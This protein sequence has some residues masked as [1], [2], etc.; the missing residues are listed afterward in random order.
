MDHLE[1]DYPERLLAA[2]APPCLSL[3]QPTHPAH[4]DKQQ[5]P[6]RFRNLVR[7]LETQL[8]QRYGTSVAEA[9]LAP[10][11]ALAEDHGFWNRVQH[12]LAVLRSPDEFRV[13]RLQRSVPEL[14]L[15]AD[16]FHTKPLLRIQQSADRFQVLALR[17]DRVELYEGNRDTVASVDLAPQV[18]A[19]AADVLGENAAERERAS[20][21]YGSAAPAAIA[22]HGTGV[23]E[24][25]RNSETERYFRAVD[26][27]TTES[28]SRPTRLPLL[29]AALPEHHHLFRRVSQNPYLLDA[30]LDVHPDDLSLEQ[31]RQRAWEAV[32]PKYMARLAGLV[33]AFHAAQAKHE[34]SADVA[35]VARAAFEGRVATMLVDADRH[36][37]GRIEA[38]TGAITLVKSG[39][40]DVGDLLDDIGEQ[41]LRT[42]GEVVVVPSDR[43]PAPGGVAAIYRY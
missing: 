38:S 43:M 14:A 23:P 16:S 31:L 3:Y 39:A 2:R 24:D 9:L 33:A 40:A 27:A 1:E 36:I 35:D 29:L 21:V 4:P 41:V 34:G 11:R 37:P 22:R 25:V 12:G 20:R 17:R 6:I 15:V 10:L 5:D 13:Y 28:H 7:S 42:R 8:Y 30:A 19:S 26:R 32:L 18:P